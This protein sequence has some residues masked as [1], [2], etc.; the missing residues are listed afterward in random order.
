MVRLANKIVKKRPEVV[1]A[2]LDKINP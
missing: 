1:L 2:S